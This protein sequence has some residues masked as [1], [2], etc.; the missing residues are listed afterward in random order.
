MKKIILAA[1][2]A[3]GLNAQ[4]QAQEL[5]KFGDFEQWITRDVKESALVGGK[6]RTLYEV[7]PTQT[8]PR[9]KHTRIRW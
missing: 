8:W 2:A 9:N 1:V 6:T 4:M 7:G 3:F 5:M